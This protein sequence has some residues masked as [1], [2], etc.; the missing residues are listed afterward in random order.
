MEI[1]NK[2]SI[3]TAVSVCALGSVSAQTPVIKGFVPTPA[4]TDSFIA[5]SYIPY[6][7]T[8]GREQAISM[9]F[10]MCASAVNWNDRVFIVGDTLVR[11][12][13]NWV[14]DH[15]LASKSSR[16]VRTDMTSFLNLLLENQTSDGFFY[17][18]LAPETDLHGG[19][20]SSEKF[21][22][23][24][25]NTG[26]GLCRL[27]I[28]A[29]V[30][31]L[32]VEGVYY[33][34][35]ATGDDQWLKK[36]LP[37]LE[38]GLNYIMTDT[39]RWDKKHGL[40]KRVY[41]I[42]TWD[43]TNEI[44]S[45]NVRDILPNAPMGIMH[46]DNTGLYRAMR[47]LAK[48][49]DR[50]GDADAAAKW[51]A[52]AD[53]LKARID[54]YLWNGKFY[55]HYLPLDKVD[56]G[57]DLEKQM[58]LSN[59]YDIN[60]MDSPEKAREVLKQ[61]RLMR[62]NFGGEFDDFRTINPAFPVFKTFKSGE[63]TNGAVGFF[64]AG[65]LAA[66]AFKNGME[67][68]GFDI[69]ERTAKKVIADGKISFLYNYDGKDVAGGPRM[70]VGSE[71]MFGLVEGLAGVVDNG[72][73]FKDVEISPRWVVSREKKAR[74]FLKYPVSGA[75]IDYA[76]EW[77]KPNGK[78][79]FTLHS[80]H[81]RATVRILL[82][83][84]AENATASVGGKIV[85]SRIEDVFSSKYLLLENFPGN[86]RVE[87][88]YSQGIEVSPY[89]TLLADSA[90]IY[91]TNNLEVPQKYTVDVRISGWESLG[92][93]TFTLMPYEKRHVEILPLKKVPNNGTEPRVII[94]RN[95]ATFFFPITKIG[96]KNPQLNLFK[97]YGATALEFLLQ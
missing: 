12:G 13:M 95:G 88:S 20:I 90:W 3:L 31:Y 78:I 76:F 14:R 94:E 25:P 36:A 63:Y 73:L 11:P 22:K 75:Y 30:E 55:K 91:I 23:L 40:A 97:S 34:W 81:D 84:G 59:S 50:V 52:S 16:Y 61:Y 69:L 21:R 58:T 32:M 46:G 51:N 66:A 10:S 7:G 5:G 64:V 57:V 2:I 54:K 17:E 77:D 6:A 82:P 18:I 92:R 24:L 70:W 45:Q 53:S 35:Q 37:K 87:I 65:E 8:K 43:F 44:A 29:D 9:L 1:F 80:K 68:Y 27:E 15:A 96:N 72:C 86:G 42:D 39:T 83:A 33:A 26:Y 67:Q 93:R 60:R 79:F 56:F 28:E 62:E 4:G 85:E 48:M 19:D 47:L 38:K 74:V 71:L 41:T 49:Y 89:V